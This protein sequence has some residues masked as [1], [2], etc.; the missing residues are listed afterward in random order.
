MLRIIRKTS[1]MNE[2]E[3]DLNAEKKSALNSKNS[4]SYSI[5]KLDTLM[6]RYREYLFNLPMLLN[7][8]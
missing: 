3:W 7:T 8:E 2:L 6:D 1:E 4:Q 5:S